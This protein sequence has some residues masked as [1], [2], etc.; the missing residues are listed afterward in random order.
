MVIKIDECIEFELTFNMGHIKD[1]ELAKKLVIQLSQ[2]PINSIY[3][4][5]GTPVIENP[6]KALVAL[7]NELEYWQDRAQTLALE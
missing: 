5:H 3:F 6:K 1:L 4:G 2:L 7:S